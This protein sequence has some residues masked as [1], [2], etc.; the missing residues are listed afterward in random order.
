VLASES[1]LRSSDVEA[2][3]AMLRAGSKSFHAA[4][5]LLPPRL[6]GPVAAVY[7]F[8]RASDDA[9]DIDTQ[10]DAL[11]KLSQSVDR[12][13]RGQPAN[14]FVERA[15]TEVVH[16]YR[17]PRTVPEALLEGFAWDLDGRRY[18]EFS[19]LAAYAVRVASTVGV[20]MTLLMGERRH[21][22]LARA[23][24]LGVA[25]QLTNIARDVGEDARSGRLYL[26][27][28]WFAASSLDVEAF[29]R[30]PS[31]SYEIRSMTRR[32][33]T[34]AAGFYALADKGISYLPA[35]CRMAI[36]SA[37]L[38]YSEIGR[39]IADAGYD[40]VSTRAHTTKREK[41]ALVA[42]ATPGAFMLRKSALQEPTLPEAK[43]LIDSVES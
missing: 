43:F 13:Y 27:T 8:C 37:R 24:D 14:D 33:L 41:I 16:A 20:M 36:R 42:R 22:V 23:C 17:I 32:L 30:E 40:S 9:V 28:Q 10:K 7:A 29:L 25:M 21:A 12:V 15:F 34:R 38:I 11:E 35:D 3:Q 31:A 26:P 2:C 39:V 1:R 5:L 4:G 19:D 18:A 6:R